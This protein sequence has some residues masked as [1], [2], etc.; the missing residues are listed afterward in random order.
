MNLDCW[1]IRSTIRIKEDIEGIRIIKE[2]RP[3]IS[4]QGLVKDDINDD[5]IRH[6]SCR[7]WS[8]GRR[9]R[10]HVINMSIEDTHSVELSTH[11]AYGRF[12][13]PRLDTWHEAQRKNKFLFF[14]PAKNYNK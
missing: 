11:G 14:F 5:V 3:I 13:Q 2:G 9:C 12:G 10:V 6:V 7:N 1:I 4:V 8:M